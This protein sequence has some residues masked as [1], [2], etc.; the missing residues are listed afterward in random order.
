MYLWKCWRDTRSTFLVLL[1]GVLAAG[2]FAGYAALDPFGWIAA[3]PQRAALWDTMARALVATAVLMIPLAGFVLGALGV[4]AE[5]EKGTLNFLLTHPR[6]RRFFLWM[7]WL[8]GA[9][10]LL[11]LVVVCQLQFTAA[12][13]RAIGLRTLRTVVLVFTL[14]LVIYSVTFL[15]TTLTRSSRKGTSLGVAVCVGYGGLH[16]WLQLWYGIKIPLF[17]DLSQVAGQMIFPVGYIF[18]WLS[19]TLALVLAAQ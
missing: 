2:A 3:N 18:G 12:H 6:S 19:V 4:G 15:M 5:F 7:S 17:W 11:A 16:L 8:V 13:D 1:G 10:E 14:A 9:A